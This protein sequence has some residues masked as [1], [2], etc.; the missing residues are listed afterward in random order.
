[1]NFTS[2]VDVFRR[3]RFAAILA[4]K[5]GVRSAEWWGQMAKRK[6][7]HRPAAPARSNRARG[8][9][10]TLMSYSVGALPIVNHVMER[11]RLADFLQEYLP[12][13]DR[14]SKISI[15]EGLLVLVRN[16]LLSREPIYG[17]GEW[18]QRFAPDLLGLEPTQVG[19][20]N[21]DRVGRCLERLFE[22]DYASM[23]LALMAH[24]VE[25][26]E[27]ELD[28]LH[29]D[30]T[31]IS[32]FGRYDQTVAE[33][34]KSGKPLLEILFGHNKDHR[35]DLKQLLFILTIARDGGIPIFFTAANG[36]VTDDKTH[37]RTWD[38]LCRLTGRRD[39]LY[40]AD[41]KLATAENM[42]YLH[43]RGGRFITV[44]PRTRS[45]DRVFRELVEASR[46]EWREI[47]S[48][49]DEE[50]EVTEV[51]EV[52]T[53]PAPTAEG[54][55]LFWFRSSRK[56]ELDAVARSGK[57][58]RT[59]GELAELRE[60][61]G[62]SRTRFR[63]RAKVHQAVEKILEKHG[64][65]AWIRTEIRQEEQESFRQERRGRPGKNTRYVRKVR[66]R[67]D[68]DYE[69]DA[70]ALAREA[71]TDG[72][73]PLITNVVAIS[74][75]EVLQAY[76]KQPMVEKRFSQL[77]TDFEVAPVYLKSVARIEGLLCVYFLALLVQALIEREVRRGMAEEGIAALPL[78]PEGR[79]CRRPCARRILDLF[80]NA[81]RHQL[82]EGGKGADILLTEL[83][84]IQ[85][86]VL[87]L[88]GVG[89]AG[90]GA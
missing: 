43:Q 81:Q 56:Q 9:G 3:G 85:R 16:Y 8:S 69:L 70:E 61:L 2:Y 7:P 20:L 58:E 79:D 76:K 47:W 84:P 41:S 50:G 89:S 57:L 30:S 65:S 74:E 11:M 63:E 32:F 88:A 15:Q 90:Y 68:L 6:R 13:P 37:R 86:K 23:V 73:F 26:F 53:H 87:K 75:L 72:L 25:E 51:F 42:A 27:V 34:V 31:T 55:R 49:T 66:T 59:L 52:S 78:Y 14:R 4:G 48:K 60:R 29:N 64:A 38:L 36:N 5:T 22:A 33:R 45:E 19:S 28:Q 10:R 24:V 67:F 82:S 44:L 46:V 71:L 80:E 83:S 40:V 12:R 39:F 54:Y 17:V 77:K 21:D 18:A 62:S 1:M 35:P